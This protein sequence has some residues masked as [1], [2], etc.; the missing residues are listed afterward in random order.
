MMQ[1]SPVGLRQPGINRFGGR[2]SGSPAAPTM[3]STANQADATPWYES[4]PFWVVV[5]LFSGYILV[6]RT[7]R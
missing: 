6:Y 5:F 7:L 1:P 4:G 2:S 3:T